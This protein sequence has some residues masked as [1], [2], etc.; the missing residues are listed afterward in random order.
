MKALTDKHLAIFRRHMV[1]VIG[2]QADLSSDETGKSELD[3]RVMAVMQEIP[4]HLFVPA[5]V[6]SAAY[7]D[8]PLPIGF[9]KTISQPFMVALMTDLLDPGP[10][11]R[12]L[13]V[14]TGLGYQTAILARLVG[15][16]WTVEIVE[17]FVESAEKRLKHVGIENV[18]LRVGDG[19]RGWADHAPYDKIIVAAGAKEVPPALIAQLKPGGRLVLPLGPSEAQ[20]LSLVQK[21]ADDTIALRGI[22]PVQF[23]ELEIG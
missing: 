2:I 9:N 23:S 4:R 5:P 11:D 3:E 15:H 6:A 22:M 12:L 1:D 16:V 10:D 18:S 7:E 13:E 20:R 21:G 8:M 17:E 19:S 14:G